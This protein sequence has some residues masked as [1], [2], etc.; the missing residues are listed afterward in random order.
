MP[1]SQMDEKQMFDKKQMYLSQI[2]EKQMF[3]KKTNKSI[4]KLD[5][6]DDLTSVREKVSASQCNLPLIRER[7]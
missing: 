2:D 3:D 5:K 1:P 6:G 7:R 4:S